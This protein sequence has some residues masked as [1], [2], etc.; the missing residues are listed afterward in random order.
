MANRAA[1][2]EHAAGRFA[3]NRKRRGR[4][5]EPREGALGKRG[6]LWEPFG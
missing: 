2:R 3:L 1:I 4:V 5:Y 6:A